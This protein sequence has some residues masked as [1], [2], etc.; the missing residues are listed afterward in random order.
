MMGGRETGGNYKAVHYEQCPGYTDHHGVW[1]NGFKCPKWGYL[2]DN[3]CCGGDKNRY[4]CPPPPSN[5]TTHVVTSSSGSSSGGSSSGSSGSS[6][7]GNDFLAGTIVGEDVILE[8]STVTVPV[9][10]IVTGAGLFIALTIVV[11]TICLCCYFCSCCNSW[12]YN[13]FNGPI[14]DDHMNKDATKISS[15]IE[16][17][18]MTSS[19][20]SRPRTPASVHQMTPRILDLTSAVKECRFSFTPQEDPPM[21]PPPLTNPHTTPITTRCY[22]N[23]AGSDALRDVIFVNMATCAD[24]GDD[25][26]KL[27][28]YCTK[29]PSSMMTSSSH[30]H[31]PSSSPF[32]NHVI[33]RYSTGK[34]TIGRTHP[35]SYPLQTHPHYFSQSPQ[36]AGQHQ[37][38]HPLYNN[39]SMTSSSLSPRTTTTTTNI[40][41]INSSNHNNINGYYGMASNNHHNTTTFQKSNFDLL[42]TTTPTSAPNDVKSFEI[43]SSS[44]QNQP[45]PFLASR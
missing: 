29:D 3:Y 2:N 10:V 17:Q 39:S 26:D 24:A 11:A 34:N 20:T 16:S 41:N 14:K 33:G 22:D 30:Y 23:N 32:A 35:P 38:H 19:S 9:V 12:K 42:T 31:N 37:A 7:G 25:V 44:A 5:K 6:S 13:V 27:S 36:Y 43:L 15:A 18:A 4:C 28:P 21:P 45:Q 8:Q 40:N 1:N